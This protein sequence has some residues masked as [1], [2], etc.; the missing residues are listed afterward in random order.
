M[1]SIVTGVCMTSSTVFYALL[2]SFFLSLGSALAAEETPEH[3]SHATFDSLLQ[4]NVSGG[5]VFYTGFDVP[6]FSAYR[7]RLATAQ[8]AS[9]SRDEQLA[10]WLNAYNASVI[11]LVLQHPGFRLVS[12][13]DG[14]FDRDSVRIAGR[15][16]TLNGIENEVIRP[17]FREPL[18][19]FGLVYPAVSSPRLPNRAFRAATV[20]KVLRQQAR[21]FIRS[22][23]GAVLDVGANV[24]MLSQLF[25]WHRA[26]FETE[27]RTLLD[28]VV[29]HAR[30]TEA[31]YIAIHRKDLTIKFLPYNWRLN[32]RNADP[33]KEDVKPY[34]KPQKSK[35]TPVK[36]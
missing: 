24:L 10:F 18:V 1:S 8:P 22:E 21:T 27:G 34:S 31:A 13:A 33:D 17:L 28:F 14:F 7:E 16:L 11:A 3:F 19:Y 4:I 15:T 9:W 6:A 36:K 12:N 26:D 30:D 5:T 20:R 32:G 35:K 29:Q 23:E 25:E 2:L